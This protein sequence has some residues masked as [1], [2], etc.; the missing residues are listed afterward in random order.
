[1]VGHTG[2]LKTPATKLAHFPRL[3][4]RV[5]SQMKHTVTWSKLISL[6]LNIITSVWE[7]IRT[8]V[9]KTI[10]EYNKVL[11]KLILM[12]FSNA[13]TSL[14]GDFYLRLKYFYLRTV[15]LS[16]L[17]LSENLNRSTSHITIYG[18]AYVI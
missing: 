10:V 7:I 5:H 12:Y 18:W 6:G 11:F 4:G 2:D 9:Q 15:V 13:T 16:N 14:K 1:M 17:Y 3:A 8:N